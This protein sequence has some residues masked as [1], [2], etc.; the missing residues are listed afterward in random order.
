MK[1]STGNNRPVDPGETEYPEQDDLFIMYDTSYGAVTSYSMTGFKFSETYNSDYDEWMITGA[2]SASNIVILGSADLTFGLMEHTITDPDG[3]YTEQVGTIET[4]KLY[5]IRIDGQSI[6]TGDGD[7]DIY[8][9]VEQLMR[10]SSASGM[11]L[12]LSSDDYSS[13]TSTTFIYNVDGDKIGATGVP[14]LSEMET[15]FVEVENGTLSIDYFNGTLDLNETLSGVTIG[16]FVDVGSLPGLSDNPADPLTFDWN[17]NDGEITA[18]E[19]NSWAGFSGT[20]PIGSDLELVV[21][22]DSTGEVTTFEI[23]VSQA[24]TWSLTSSDMS[25]TPYDGTYSLLLS[26]AVDG[27]TYTYSANMKF[28]TGNN[29]PVD[30][31]EM[32]D[33]IRLELTDMSNGVATVA[34]YFGVDPDENG[35]IG[36]SD[37]KINFD[38]SEA[39]LSSAEFSFAAGIT[40]VPGDPDL[41]KS[42]IALSMFALPDFQDYET[43]PFVTFTVDMANE[44]EQLSLQLS[45]IVIDS[46][47][48]AGVSTVLELNDHKL[49]TTVV[50]RDGSAFEG[51]EIEALAGQFGTNVTIQETD[52][53]DVYAVVANYSADVSSIDFKLS[54]SKAIIEF[55]AGSAIDGWTGTV[56]DTVSGVVSYSAFGAIDGSLDLSAGG[57]HVLA[58]FKLVDATDLFVTEI[59]LNGNDIEDV[60]IAQVTPDSVSGNTTVMSIEAGHDVEVNG[61][62]AVDTAANKSVGAWDAL[63]ALRLAV[64][65]NPLKAGNFEVEADAFHFIAAD[66]NQDGKVRADDALNILKYAVGFDDH[67]AQWVFVDSSEELSGINN[68]SVSYFDGLSLDGVNANVDAELTAVLIG[69]VDASYFG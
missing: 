52:E 44:A 53:A 68:T 24:G 6:I 34:A 56:N 47:E 48:Q 69:D 11:I 26:A 27:Q 4:G 1:F 46:I 37:V 33:S 25:N 66:I 36:S 30:P 21:K 35:G 38:P 12:G 64:G 43:V 32:K 39:D 31:G 29:R 60:M 59:A 10:A 45:G 2:P 8:P 42:S 22:E 15:L 61:V 18:N 55:T 58:T 49:T 67:E 65:L 7:S 13:G 9:F 41:E 54:S 57:D 17:D 14:T 28:S 51:A 50:G 40:G 23:P 3:S 19:L 5:D 20:A 63:Q 62:L 16:T